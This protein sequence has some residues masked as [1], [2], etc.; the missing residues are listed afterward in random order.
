MQDRE[1]GLTYQVRR[2]AHNFKKSFIES[3]NKQFPDFY[4][5]GK[6]I[7]EVVFSR[8]TQAH[9]DKKGRWRIADL[10]GNTH[11]EVVKLLKEKAEERKADVSIVKTAL[12][13][14]GVMDADS[15]DETI[16]GLLTQKNNPFT[17]RTIDTLK[18]EGKIDNKAHADL[19]RILDGR[20][21]VKAAKFEMRDRMEI[22]PLAN[23]MGRVFPEA[24]SREGIDELESLLVEN[25]K[26]MDR[27]ESLKYD[28]E[29]EDPAERHKNFVLE[30]QKLFGRIRDNYQDLADFS[31][32]MHLL[33]LQCNDPHVKYLARPANMSSVDFDPSWTLCLERLDHLVGEIDKIKDETMYVASQTLMQD[34]AINSKLVHTN[35]FP[36]I[37]RAANEDEREMI[38][39]FAGIH[40]P[41]GTFRTGKDE[42]KSVADQV[43]TLYAGEERYRP[44]AEELTNNIMHETQ[45]IDSLLERTETE[46]TSARMVTELR[47]AVG[48]YDRLLSDPV[49]MGLYDSAYRY[50]IAKMLRR[51]RLE[52]PFY[53]GNQIAREH[54]LDPLKL[55]SPPIGQLDPRRPD[56]LMNLWARRRDLVQRLMY[57][58]AVLDASN[59]R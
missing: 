26:L 51:Q 2:S 53:V 22:V 27:F 34:S 14:S 17:H 10:V 6:T 9:A 23:Q 4:V 40:K 47:R 43:E 21:A 12:Q 3:V 29:I 24:L 59:D 42:V 44:S 13:A 46:G 8:L 58:S 45:R 16:E 18:S 56:A 1:Q 38:S 57:H 31:S 36:R 20:D 41:Q 39:L 5:G 11:Q 55:N 52:I 33:R 50:R 54:G 48:Y 7:G 35:G 28:Q 19:T 37:Y 49:S 32:Q 15:I 25:R 30:R